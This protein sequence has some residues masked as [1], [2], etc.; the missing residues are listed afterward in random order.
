M[1]TMTSA[2]ADGARERCWLEERLAKRRAD[3]RVGELAI[4]NGS[5]PNWRTVTRFWA[6]RSG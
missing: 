5:E 2:I 1:N 4:G 3:G 6:S